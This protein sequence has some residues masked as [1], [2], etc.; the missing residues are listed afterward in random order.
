[1]CLVKVTLLLRSCSDPLVY[2]V[3]LGFNSTGCLQVCVN[4]L[5][6]LTER[7]FWEQ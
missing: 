5:K 3:N 6:Y 2:S 7:N 1:M 4:Q